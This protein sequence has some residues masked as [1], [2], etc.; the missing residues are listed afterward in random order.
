MDLGQMFLVGFQSP[1]V[2][3]SEWLVNNIVEDR[4]GGVIL[5][6]RNIS[7]R[8]QNFTSP[9]MLLLLTEE[10]NSVSDHTLLIGVDQEGGKVC[11]LKQKD[12]FP[13]MKSAG[14]LATQT[15]D[16]V[17]TEAELLAKTL[18]E[19][20]ITLNFAPVVDLNLYPQN[21]IIG[22]YERSF[23]DIP[24]QVVTFATRVIAAHHRYNLACC[25]KHFP[26][27][28][29]SRDDSHHG[30]VDITY[31][32]DDIELKPYK[33]LIQNGY[34]D[35]VMT[36]HLVHR[37]LDPTGQPAT[38]SQPMLTTILRN[39]LHFNG[40]VF[41]DDLQM[42]AITRG[43]SYREAVQQAVLAG[44]DI[45]VVGNNLKNQENAVGQGIE[46]IVELLDQ[47]KVSPE[48]IQDSIDRI[49]TLK[50]KIAGEQSWT[51]NNQAT[52]W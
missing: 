22:G 51:S 43:W 21:P 16:V 5:F 50:H 45:L 42:A 27:H 2:E 32:W 38:L 26:G 29:S 44:V 48:R 46:A 17:E 35:G 25:I 15:L 3:E 47:E 6:D 34:E 4:L 8:I 30:F 1:K 20:G 28:G 41:S 33:Q 39:Q 19:F 10:L 9:E 52:V 7:G 14:Y 31:S 12:G 23:G 18:K 13:E 49:Q 40:V 24:A 11:R 36:G 37:G